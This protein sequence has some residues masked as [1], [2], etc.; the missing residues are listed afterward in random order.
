MTY[1]LALKLKNAG[2]PNLGGGIGERY[3]Y[4]EPSY[5]GLSRSQACYDPTLSELIEA[6]GDRFV[7]LNKY[8]DNSGWQ[9]RGID[10]KFEKDMTGIG[11]TPEEA[12]AKLW[13]EINKK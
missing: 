9:T 1:E 2:F 3:I 11:K 4:P 6:C 12:V 13:L 8:A 10:K 7:S 5:L